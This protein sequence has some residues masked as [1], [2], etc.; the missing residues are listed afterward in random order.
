MYIGDKFNQKSPIEA[1]M[2]AVIHES[3]HEVDLTR[4]KTTRSIKW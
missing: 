3:G 1:V 2:V 4:W